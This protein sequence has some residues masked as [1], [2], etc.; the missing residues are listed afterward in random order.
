M[1]QELIYLASASPRRRELLGQ[2][3]VAHR[4]HPVSVDESRLPGEDPVDFTRRL[5][6]DKATTAWREL[7]GASGSLVI[8]ADTVVVIDDEVLGKPADSASAADMLARLSGRSHDVLTAVA[9]VMEGERQI[10]VSTSTVRFRTLAP[11]EIGAYVATGEPLDKA[12]GY[13]IQGLAAVFIERLDGSFSGVMGLPLFETAVLMRGFGHD[14]LA[15][16]RGGNP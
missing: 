15:A 3:G 11:A 7:Q 12:G 10:C 8:G 16:T 6:L 4:T 9:G 1:N 14:V 5:A 13:A 2:I